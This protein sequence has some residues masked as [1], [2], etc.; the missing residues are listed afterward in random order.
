MHNLQGSPRVGEER[1][2]VVTLSAATKAGYALPLLGSA[3]LSAKLTERGCACIKSS[4][5]T[6]MHG[7]AKYKR[8][9]P[10]PTFDLRP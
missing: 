4:F 1:V 9:L 7:E 3:G 8:V 5:K 10:I 6:V 2:P